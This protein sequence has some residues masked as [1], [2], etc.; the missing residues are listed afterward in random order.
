MGVVKKGVHRLLGDWVVCE[1]DDVAGMRYEKNIIHRH[2]IL[3][4]GILTGTT[5]MELLCGDIV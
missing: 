4:M 1:A 5:R 3:E 2:M